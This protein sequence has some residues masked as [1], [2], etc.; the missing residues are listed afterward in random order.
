MRRLLPLAEQLG[1]YDSLR[2]RSDLS[3]GLTVGVMLIPQGMAYALIAGL[4]PIYGLYAS[5]V[6]LVVYA[7]MG[8]SRQLA[9]GPVAI[10]SI[11]VAAGVA[12]LADGDGE[13]YIRLSLLLALMVGALQ[14][15]MGLLRF[16]FL[17]NFLSHPVLAGFTSAA[18]LIIGASQLRHLVGMDLPGGHGVHDI[19]LALIRNLGSV[20]LPTLGLGLAG[21]LLLVGLKRLGPAI[22]GALVLVV[23]GTGLSWLLGMAEAGIRVVGEV[24]GGLP[25]PMLPVL[26]WEAARAL[27]PVAL[28]I[29]MVG[30]MESIAI[31]KVYATQQGY[32]V[33]PNQELTALGVANL[34]GAFFR[35]YPVTGGFSRT[36]V[37]ARAGATSGVAG[38]VSAG[39]VAL[40]LLF[41]TDL[42]QH[43]PN[44]VLASLVMVAVAG[45][46][47]WK[48][49]VHLWRIDRQ[50][51]SMM[52]V[53]FGATLALGIEAGILVGVVASLGLLVYR[54]SRPHVAEMGRLPG[55]RSFRNVNRHPEAVRPEGVAVLRIDASLTFANAQLLR[56][57]VRGFL[58]PPKDR[59]RPHT[60]VLDF[61]P[62][63]G[64][65]STSLHEL[66]D[67]AETLAA[68]G[69][70][71]R[72]AGIHG[73]ILDR[74]E[75]AGVAERVGRERF[76]LE[77]ADAVE[78]AEERRH[79]EP[80]AEPVRTG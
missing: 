41:L 18:A 28:T 72:I 17:T 32:D 70:E 69:V 66:M 34:A 22:P 29:A 51:L 24:P 9:V 42:F 30:F 75:R 12:P 76:H 2:A 15:A 48:E 3:A 77:V 37:N 68:A 35:A 60:V 78:A 21:I 58:H 33:R 52:L 53:T 61:H 20:H 55:S 39:V 36:A 27:L 26:E 56:D 13:R 50:D 40:T 8:T 79:P 10:V 4:P 62:V 71:L 54:M 6:P 74:L 47:D 19:L 65:D 11:L 23:L 46:V 44:A 16:G 25:G 49:A 67:L 57:R 5:L 1:G 73:P 7:L 63:N 80:E 14:L 38:L 64:V 43:L 45:L 59:T 31:A